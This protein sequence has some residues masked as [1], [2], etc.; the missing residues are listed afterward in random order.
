MTRPGKLSI[1]LISEVAAFF[2]PFLLGVYWA[3]VGIGLE[4]KAAVLRCVIAGLATLMLVVWLRA[5]LTRAET[6]F[7]A[8]FGLLALLLIVPSLTA[9]DSARALKDVLKLVLLLVTGLAMARA[10]RHGRSA[11]WFGYGMLVGSTVTAGLILSAYIRHMGLTLPTYEGLRILKE[12]LSKGEGFPLNPISFTAFFMYLIGLCLVPPKALTWCLGL[13][14]FGVSSFL[15][16]SRAPLGIL[17]L[18]ALVATGLHWLR[19]RSFVLRVSGFLTLLLLTSVIVASVITI[20]SRK[21]VTISEGR[22]VAW[23]VAWSKFLERPLSGYGYE[24]WQDDLAAR[25][26]G[27]EYFHTSTS[28]IANGGYHNQ[29]ITLLAEEGLVG[30]LPAM[31][32]V[33][34]LLRCCRWLAW[35]T[36]IPTISRQVILLGCLFLLLRAAV[37]VPGLFGYANDPADYL[38]YCCVAVVVSRMSVE[39]DSRRLTLRRLSSEQQFSVAVSA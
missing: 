32:I 39:E 12:V 3:P 28:L 8:L 21:W 17:L 31:A 36:S 1:S 22:T 16:G 38:A 26:A 13:F 34:M 14:V 6:K 9:T 25:L 2:I 4:L 33:G 23:S 35:R 19:A 24:S 11:R 20:D 18:S 30:F 29:Y 15:T 7:A 27:G 37:E 5:P 10:L